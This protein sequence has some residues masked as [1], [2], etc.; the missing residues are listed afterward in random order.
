MNIGNSV[1]E[2]TETSVECKAN[3]SYPA[4]SVDILFYIGGVRKIHDTL[5]KRTQSDDVHDGTLETFVFT[6]TTDRSMNGKIAKCS[7]CKNGKKM[8][9]EAEATLN[10]TCE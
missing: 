8:Q 10:I 1:K 7:L 4:H 9:R 2:N 5:L 3:T 6:F